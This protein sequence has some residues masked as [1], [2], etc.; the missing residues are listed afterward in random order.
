MEGSNV[1]TTPPLPPLPLPPLPLPPLP[2]P[3][4][5]PPPRRYIS[6][7]CHDFIEGRRDLA[8]FAPPMVAL[9]K[10]RYAVNLAHQQQRRAAAAVAAGGHAATF[11][12]ARV[13]AAAGVAAAA[14]PKN[15][16]A[17]AAGTNSTVST[18]VLPARVS[19]VTSSLSEAAIAARRQALDRR[20][21]ER[22]QLL[23]MSS[24]RARF[25]IRAFDSAEVAAWAPSAEDDSFTAGPAGA[26]GAA[27][28]AELS[29]DGGAA[30]MPSLDG[31]ATW[32]PG[33][34]AGQED[35]PGNDGGDEAPRAAVAAAAPPSAPRAVLLADLLQEED[36][37]DGAKSQALHRGAGLALMAD[38]SALDSALWDELM[39]G[40]GDAAAESEATALQDRSEWAAAPRPGSLSP[41]IGLQD[42]DFL[43][44]GLL[45]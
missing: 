44:A 13:A 28:E 42:S 20:D 23:S 5:P 32:E 29:D 6:Q 36:T 33:G 25:A 38:D 10:R 22:P 27:G 31:A 4:P 15:A 35:H 26:G 24:R 34:R 2:L 37:D 8:A 45:A 19:R 30:P 43:S 11:K 12:K 18:S 21:S 39:D 14:R 40:L 16:A 3:P 7:V 41:D 1:M 9:A 17:S